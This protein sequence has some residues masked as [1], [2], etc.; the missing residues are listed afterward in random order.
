M[1]MTVVNAGNDLLKEATSFC[2]LQPS[3]LNNVVKELPA[4][5]VLHNHE[6]VRRCTDD[7]V[8]ADD[9][10]MAEEREVLDF[11]ANLSNDIQ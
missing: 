3:V 10:R 1:T 8:E 7:L 2:G 4:G 6:N 9:M 11:A 5:N